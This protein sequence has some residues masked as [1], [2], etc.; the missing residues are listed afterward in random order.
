MES[1]PHGRGKK[2]KMEKVQKVRGYTLIELMIVVAVISA[3]VL[4]AVGASLL[5]YYLVF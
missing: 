1:L 5:I 4:G 3:F 2:G